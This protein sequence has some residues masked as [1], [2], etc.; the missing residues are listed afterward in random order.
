[1]PLKEILYKIKYFKNDRF[2]YLA[3][4]VSQN[5]GKRIKKLNFPGIYVTKDF[6]RYYPFG[7]LT[8]QLIGFT[9]I[10]GIGIEGVEKSF[11]NT[12]AGTPEKRKIRTDKFGNV[13][14]NITLIKKNAPHDINLSIDIR[15]QEV[16]CR[17][18]N[19][20][21]DLNKA[22]SG[23]AI[24]I[25]IKTGEILAIANSPT[26]NPNNLKNVSMELIRNKAVT[27]V[28]EP[29]S[30]VK[31]MIIMKALQKKIITPKSVINTTPFIINKHIIQDVS[32]HKELSITDI[33][34]KSSNI[35]VSKLALL[36][37]ESELTDIYSKFGLGKSTNSGLIGE[38]NGIYPKKKNWTNLDKA[39]FSFG[40]GLMATPL[41][42]VNVYTTIGR[43]GLYKPLS[44]IK[45]ESETKGI[46]IFSKS[47]VKIVLNMLQSV[48]QPG[49]VGEK[50]AIKGY[51]IA[52][53]TGT[54]KKTNSQGK[55]IDR[56]VAYTIG[57]APISN[58]KLSLI[59]IINDPRAGKYY[60]GAISAPVFHSIMSFALKTK[61]I[62][63]D[64][65]L[66]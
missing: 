36:M 38:T 54:A 29:G 44:I 19:H 3:K 25:N 5:I 60:G 47:L 45:V 53:K 15:L 20:A 13:I 7:T 26:Y 1:M 4:K 28:F 49:G 30:T 24:L 11:N 27:D 32:Y 6:Q 2:T 34:K 8:S 39:T 65:L 35:G 46:Q 55:Y 56:Y 64:N 16:I 61:H 17:E 10:D 52:V 22:K 18:L 63:P 66:K 48:T 14:E 43:Y 12:L 31:P 23:T 51:K 41:Q 59:I 33:L 62:K 9:N 40:Y 57:I 58:P 21:V 42:L 37:S 50:A